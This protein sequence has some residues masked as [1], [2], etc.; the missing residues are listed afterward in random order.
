MGADEEPSMA[1][2]RP[3]SRRP[4]LLSRSVE[5]IEAETRIW[6]SAHRPRGANAV[7]ENRSWLEPCGEP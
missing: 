7:I 2:K 1:W 4:E 3:K 5:V 6:M